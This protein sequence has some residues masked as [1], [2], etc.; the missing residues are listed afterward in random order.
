MYFLYYNHHGCRIEYDFVF[1]LRRFG[2]RRVLGELTAGRGIDG[3]LESVSPSPCGDGILAMSKQWPGGR[4]CCASAIVS[5]ILLQ[6]DVEERNS[7][8]GR[9]ADL[10]FRRLCVSGRRAAIAGAFSFFL[11]GAWGSKRKWS[12]LPF[13]AIEQSRPFACCYSRVKPEYALRDA[14]IFI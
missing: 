12:Y 10:V 1:I 4:C 5:G 13:A 6:E 9:V 11:S 3:A 7:Q 2:G 8:S 14:P